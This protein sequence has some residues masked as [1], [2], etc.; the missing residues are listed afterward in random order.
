MHIHSCCKNMILL[1]SVAV[2]IKSMT[3]IDDSNIHFTFNKSR[4]RQNHVNQLLDA[5]IT[6]NVE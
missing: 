1:Y 6:Y 5:K 2:F 4:L 3:Q